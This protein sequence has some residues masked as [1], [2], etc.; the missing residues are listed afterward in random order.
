MSAKFP[1]APTYQTAERP[2]QFRVV[3]LLVAAGVVLLLMAGVAI[4][5]VVVMVPVWR[6]SIQ[7][8]QDSDC[9]N[10]LK[11]IAIALQNYH[12]ANNRFPAAYVCDASGKPAH[13]WRVAI[14]PYMFNDHRQPLYKYDEPWNGPSNSKLVTKLAD[15]YRCPSDSTSPKGMTNYVAVVGKSTIWPAPRFTTLADVRD[16]ATNTL[17]VVEISHSDI[18]WMEP[19]D[20]PV[21]ELAE[22]LKPGHKPQLLGHQIEGGFV[23]FADGHIEFL[24]RDVTMQRLQALVT[25]AGKDTP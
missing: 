9:R 10:N 18:H 3:H 25:A 11:Q 24:S 21:E 4:A 8:A 5:L 12:D 13:S 22:W 23:A 7:V 14:W 6:R 20:L 15:Y 17:L 19:R 1:V 2:S 16:G